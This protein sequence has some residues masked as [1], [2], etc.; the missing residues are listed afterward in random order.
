MSFTR[1]AMDATLDRG[2]RAFFA[3]GSYNTN[4]HTLHNCS[5][6]HKYMYHILMSHTK[7]GMCMYKCMLFIMGRMKLICILPSKAYSFT[8]LVPR[9]PHG[10]GTR[11]IA[12]PAFQLPEN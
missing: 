3:D 12:L 10:L 1:L 6:Q 11:L 4:K 9:P 8:S 7:K 2:L 5:S